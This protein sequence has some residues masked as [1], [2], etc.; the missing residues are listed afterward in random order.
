MT[1]TE[2]AKRIRIH[3]R[4]LKSQELRTVSITEAL[5]V[6]AAVLEDISAGRPV[7]LPDNLKSPTGDNN[8]SED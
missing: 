3:A 8:E 1:Y 2:A 4:V 5:D 7:M 6:A